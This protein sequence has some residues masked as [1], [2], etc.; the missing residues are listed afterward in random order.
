[1]HLGIN[2]PYSQF[3]CQCP[4]RQKLFSI[5]PPA[6]TVCDGSRKKHKCWK[7]REN[8]VP[9]ILSAYLSI[10]LM[11][12]DGADF[13]FLSLCIL[14][15]LAFAQREKSLQKSWAWLF[16]LMAAFHKINENFNQ[17]VLL[18]ISKARRWDFP[19]IIHQPTEKQKTL[20]SPTEKKKI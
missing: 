17:Y 18:G 14:L 6:L 12:R 19:Q 15:L 20:C 4:G 16:S 2:K 9:L 5:S 10:R 3:H 7:S 8:V 11:K 13:E 1:M